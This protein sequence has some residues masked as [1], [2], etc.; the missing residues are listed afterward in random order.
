LATNVMIGIGMLFLLG[1]CV[2]TSPASTCN[3]ARADLENAPVG[4]TIDR[5]EFDNIV[6]PLGNRVIQACN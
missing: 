5:S 1:K 4:R 3:D 2:S 6:T